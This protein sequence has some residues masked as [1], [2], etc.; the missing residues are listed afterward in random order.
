MMMNV[1]NVVKKDTGTFKFK[2]KGKMSVLIQDILQDTENIL[3]VHQEVEVGTRK[4]S[5]TREEVHHLPQA[6]QVKAEV[7]IEKKIKNADIKNPPPL[8]G[9]NNI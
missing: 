9:L 6:H 7:E 4:K 5:I 2:K 1:G 8:Q 3:Q